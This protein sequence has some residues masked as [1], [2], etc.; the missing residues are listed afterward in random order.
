ME[1]QLESLRDLCR[2]SSHTSR[3][4][5]EEKRAQLPKY[6]RYASRSAAQAASAAPAQPPQAF[7]VL[8]APAAF[9]W[10]FCSAQ[11]AA[12]AESV[13]PVHIRLVVAAGLKC[14]LWGQSPDSPVMTLS[15]GALHTHNPWLACSLLSGRSH[16][17][18]CMLKQ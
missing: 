10:F 2:C 8:P 6:V 12:S 13:L 9:L 16:V 18:A 4:S 1:C 14:L 17:H 7:Q 5:Q 15:A 11:G 3:R